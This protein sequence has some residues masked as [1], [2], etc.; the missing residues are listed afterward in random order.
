MQLNNLD[1]FAL[2]TPL[3]NVIEAGFMDEAEALGIIVKMVRL[4]L[5]YKE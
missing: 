5:L 1:H 4:N 2:G 3:I